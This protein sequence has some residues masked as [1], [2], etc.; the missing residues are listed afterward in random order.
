MLHIPQNQDETTDHR[1]GHFSPYG[2]IVCTLGRDSLALRT[3]LSLDTS[4][5]VLKCPDSS[6]ASNQC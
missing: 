3:E 5:L 1:V 4:V 2:G 6:D